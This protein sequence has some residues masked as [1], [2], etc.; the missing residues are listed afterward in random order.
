MTLVNEMT[1]PRKQQVSL[2]DTPYYHCISRCVRRAYLCGSD[3]VTKKSYEHR[4]GWVEKRLLFLAQVFSIDVCA[5]AVMHNHTHV[6]LHIDQESTKDWTMEEVINR[7]H[8]VSNGHLLSQMYV[9]ESQR[10]RLNSA[11]LYTLETL[12]HTWKKRLFDVSWFMRMLNEPIARM[13]NK[14]DE[15]TGRFWEGRFKSQPL[16][17]DAA[18]IAC[19]A[20]VDLNPVRAGFETLPEESKHTS[21]RK[22][23]HSAK[24]GLKP[25]ALL[26]FIGTNEHEKRKGIAFEFLDYLELLDMAGQVERK[27]VTLKQAHYRKKL[28][29]S[30]GLTEDNWIE[31]SRSFGWYFRG[32]VGREPALREYHDNMG[33]QRTNGLGACRKL[34]PFSL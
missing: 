28:L 10:K 23:V 26:P 17:D 34:M 27:S 32:A 3:P 2:E 1:K 25:K 9:N 20:Y 18:L 7:W 8:R 14:E 11:Q 4:R 33:Y 16:L 22:R 24:R 13:A 15:C 30:I 19:M 29:C 31:L 12:C 21:V 5:Y 6:V